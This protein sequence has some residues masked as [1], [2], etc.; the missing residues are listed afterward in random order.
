MALKYYAKH[1]KELKGKSFK[2]IENERE[3]INILHKYIKIKTE[4][5]GNRDFYNLIKGVA[6]EGSKLNSILDESQIIP[7]IEEYIERNFAGITYKIDV[8]FELQCEDIKYEIYNLKEMLKDKIYNNKE[9]K[10]IK[11]TSV[12]LFKKIYNE[13]CEYE[14]NKNLIGK[15]YK[16]KLDHIVKYE[17]NKC[18]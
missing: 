5:H 17:L 11:V 18:L 16:I 13:A 12:F 4:F 7:I 14:N 1:V 8:D 10:L 2:E 3:Y 15:I 6:I 9:D